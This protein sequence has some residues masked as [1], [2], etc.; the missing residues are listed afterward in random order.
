MSRCNADVSNILI[1]IETAPKGMI[2][3]TKEEFVVECRDKKPTFFNVQLQIMVT[4]PS[5]DSCRAFFSC[6]R[7]ESSET[8]YVGRHPETD[9][10]STHLHLDQEAR[11]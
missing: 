6:N 8:M 10:I 9:P 4:P 3:I 1:L 5:L 2:M 7:W 11:N